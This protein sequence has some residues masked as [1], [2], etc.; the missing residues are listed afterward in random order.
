MFAVESSLAGDEVG[1]IGH[2]IHRAELKI[3]IIGN[4]ENEVGLLGGW[5]AAVLVVPSG[6]M[7]VADQQERKAEKA[8]TWPHDGQD[9]ERVFGGER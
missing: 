9:V 8:K 2:V 6:H 3:L 7:A 4:D 1:N 5:R